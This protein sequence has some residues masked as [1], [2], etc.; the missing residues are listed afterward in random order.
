[1]PETGSVLVAGNHVSYIDPFAHAYF[2]VKR[3]RRPRFLGKRELFDVPVLGWALD[4]A[5]Q[6]PVD[7]GTPSDPAPLEQAERALEA[8]ECVLVYPEGTV[9]T[10]PAYLPMRGKTGTVRLS[11]ATGVPITPVAVWGSQAVWQKSGRGSLKFARPIFVRAGAP[12]DLSAYRDQANDGQVLRKLTDEL[13]AE[14]TRLVE[15]LR[16]EYP[17][18]WAA[19]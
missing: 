16:D 8:G 1:V 18:R 5:R 12:I 9:T 19:G 6:I 4:N 11:L 2:V 15:A 3:R 10:D 13:M 7:R 14:L 17:K